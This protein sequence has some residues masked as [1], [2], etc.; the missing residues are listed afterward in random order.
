MPVQSYNFVKEQSQKERMTMTDYI[1]QV[2][3]REERKVA[4][5]KKEV[6]NDINATLSKLVS[7]IASET[8][9]NE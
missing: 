6:A 5:P 4:E 2:L 7:E 8:K 9:G 1:I 3:L